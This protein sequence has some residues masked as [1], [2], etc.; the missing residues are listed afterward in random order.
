MS[1]YMPGAVQVPQPGGVALDTSLPP[2]FVW[3]IT[4]DPLQP[5]GSQPDFGAVASYLQSKEWCPHIMWNPFT[6]YMEQYYPASVGSRALEFNDGDGTACVQ[7]EIF[8]TPNCVVD[9]IKYATVADT[10]LKGW[11][12]LLAWADGLGVPRTWPMGAPQWQ[13]NPRDAGIWNGNAGHYGHC[14]S[15]GDTHTDP[16]PMPDLNTDQGF[17][18]SL[19]DDEQRR[20]LAAADRIN[21]V[22]TDPVAKVLTTSDVPGI[23]SAIIGAPIKRSGQMGGQTSLGAM[24]AGSDDL[25]LRTPN[26]VLSQTFVL[27]DGTK[28]NLPGLLAAINA[29]PAATVTNNTV[30]PASVDIEAL[31]ARLKAELPATVLAALA[32]KLTV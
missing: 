3:H 11:A 32:A 23:V 5:D 30:A 22:I 6:G 25:F 14:N 17:L 19:S 13:N 8:F 4:W 18:M 2:R 7:V 29:K 20:I 12:E 27:A 26:A 24:A 16:G 31:V 21:G 10:P 28:T 9:G 15:P 1:D